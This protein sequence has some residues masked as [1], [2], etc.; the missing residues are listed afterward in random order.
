MHGEDTSC[1]QNNTHCPELNF[2]FR[3]ESRE[4]WH[5]KA[6]MTKHVA[7]I[8]G[9]FVNFTATLTFSEEEV[10]PSNIWYAFLLENP[11]KIVVLPFFVPEETLFIIGIGFFKNNIRTRS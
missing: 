7:P 1:K 4:N 11:G 6:R 9:E 5:L 10:L 3:D 2:I 8:Y